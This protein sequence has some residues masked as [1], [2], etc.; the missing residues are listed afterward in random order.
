MKPKIIKKKTQKPTPHQ[1][2]RY[3]T[4][5]HN[6]QKP[7]VLT[8]NRVHRRFRG[9]SLTPNTGDGRK[10][11]PS[12][13]CQRLTGA[14]GPHHQGACAAAAGQ[15]IFCAEIVTASPQTATKPWWKEQPSQ[16]LSSTPMPGCTAEK[17]NR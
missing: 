4:I 17:M 14:P 15:R 8:H 13:C 16:P 6:W 12:S 2:D 7:R 3:V 5:K 11:K 1:S 10:R 9:P